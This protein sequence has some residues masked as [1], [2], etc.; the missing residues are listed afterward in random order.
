MICDSNEMK[1]DAVDSLKV[2]VQMT[3]DQ[4]T[5]DRNLYEST[6][7]GKYF[8]SYAPYLAILEH[9][10]KRPGWSKPSAR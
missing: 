9:N 2:H 1:I 10:V 4:G 7:S 8:H 5:I 6:V 3:T